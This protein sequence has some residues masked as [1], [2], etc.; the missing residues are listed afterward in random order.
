MTLPHRLLGNTGLALSV[1]GLG[2]VKLGR[3][4]GVKYPHSFTIPNDEQALDLLQYAWDLGINWL[5]TAPAYGSS[6]LRLGAL[7]KILQLPFLVCTKVGEEFIDGV[8]RFDFSPEHT[9]VS[10]ERSLQRLMRDELD[11]VLVHSDGN[12]IDI[13]EREGTLEM[14]EWLKK[15]G[16]IRAFGVSTKTVAGGLLAL[17]RSDLV[18]ATLNLNHRDEIPVMEYAERH[19]KGV[20]I[21][22]AFASG[23][24]DS[25]YKDP[26]KS[27]LDLILNQPGVTAVTIGTINRQNLKHNVMAAEEVLSY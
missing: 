15:Q 4:Q 11:M 21:K 24:L 20:L 2:T 5:D 17:E 8:S 22:K 19:N 3:D 26:V 7:M 14:L 6:E 27:S 25:N 12:D 13:I 18:M 16:K 1:V 9:Q 10:V 23:H